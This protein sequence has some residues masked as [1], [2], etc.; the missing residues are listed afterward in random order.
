MA[1]DEDLRERGI[2]R[3]GEKKRKIFGRNKNK[4]N[5]CHAS[6]GGRKALLAN[7][8]QLLSIS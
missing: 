2:E 3:D 6:T 1:F 5:N 8:N 7:Y 4:N